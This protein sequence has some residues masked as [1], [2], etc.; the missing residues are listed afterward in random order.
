[1]EKETLY[2]CGELLVQPQIFE[3]L[4][5]IVMFWTNLAK[6]IFHG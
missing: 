2:M 6:K 1:M 5:Y 4:D 3:G